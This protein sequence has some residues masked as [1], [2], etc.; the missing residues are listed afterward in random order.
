M[1]NQVATGVQI[2]IGSEEIEQ[3]SRLL[4]Y[5]E[6]VWEKVDKVPMSSSIVVPGSISVTF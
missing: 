4:Y 6:R 3:S 2:Q 1:H 5:F